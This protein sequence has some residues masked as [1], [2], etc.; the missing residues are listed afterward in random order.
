MQ[1]YYD[2]IIIGAGPAGLSAGLHAS[3]DGSKRSILLVDKTAPWEHT[4]RCAEAVGRRGFGEAIGIRPH[5]IRQT[6]GK[7]C[8]HAPGGIAVT[9][10]DKN[11][12]YIIDRAAMQRDI[13][14]DLMARGVACRFD[15]CVTRLSGMKNFRRTVEF[16]DGSAVLGRVII[17]AAGPIAG[18]GA[19][20][21]VQRKPADLEPA[22]FVLAEGVDLPSDAVH[23][24]MTGEFAP[25][26]YA[27][28]FPRGTGVNIGI[29]IGSAFKG[30]VNLRRLLDGFLERHFR[31]AAIGGGYGGTIPCAAGRTRMASPG[32]IKTGDAANTVNPISRAG[33]T[34]ALLSG[35]LAGSYAVAMLDAPG[36]PELRKIAG[37]YE[38]AWNKKRGRRHEKLAR[39]KPTF[40][41]VPDNDYNRAAET[42]SHLGSDK[43]TMFR[44]FKAALGRFPRLLWALRHMV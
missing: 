34:E 33:I 4:I 23:I 29:V 12:G 40:A 28:V 43:I 2:I 27:W 3:K 21:A 1:E 17:D 14:Q 8:F 13:A 42:L 24:Y 25:G 11:G 31:G 20:E 35:G 15:R 44:I 6:I 10:T 32:F 22:Y 7:A 18:L 9:Y 38:R 37:E 39:V 19:E 30:R 41:R 5:W 26:G 36:E 16:A